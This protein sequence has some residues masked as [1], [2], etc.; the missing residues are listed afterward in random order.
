MLIES[1]SPRRLGRREELVRAC[2]YLHTARS[3]LRCLARCHC[4]RSVRLSVLQL[5]LLLTH[6]LLLSLALGRVLLRGLLPVPAAS[7]P[8]VRNDRPWRA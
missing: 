8:A 7:R 4:S 6:Q 1:T 3:L 5:L 2:E